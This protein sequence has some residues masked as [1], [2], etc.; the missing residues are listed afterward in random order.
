M[1]D[2]ADK[3]INE[4]NRLAELYKKKREALLSGS[5][6]TPAAIAS[7]MG[8]EAFEAMD[9]MDAL[10]E[11]DVLVRLFPVVSRENNK[12]DKTV[13]RFI[14]DKEGIDLTNH[15]SYREALGGVDI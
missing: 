7:L 9:V 10:L 13:C 8:P 12:S 3:L 6:D 1:T 2:Q 15:A 14:V 11:D 5:S 4:Y